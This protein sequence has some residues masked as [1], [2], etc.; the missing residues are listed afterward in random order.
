[1]PCVTI[2]SPLGPVSASYQLP[3]T[4]DVL[5]TDIARACFQAA[6]WR[7]APRCNPQIPSPVSYGWIFKA[8]IFA[9]IGSDV[10]TTCTTGGTRTYILFLPVKLLLFN[11]LMFVYQEYFVGTVLTAINAKL[12]QSQ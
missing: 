11:K 6:I 4:E 9:L 3:P 5:N 2:F 10:T 8:K 1:M 7:R 12:Y